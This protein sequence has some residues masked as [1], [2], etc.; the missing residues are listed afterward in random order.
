MKPPAFEYHA[1]GSIAETVELLD[2]LEDAKVLAGGQSL[3]PL[4]NFRLARPAHLV[5]VNGVGELDRVYRRD[6]G[7]A[8]GATVRQATAERH[9]LLGERCPLLPLAL[10]HVAHQVI[11]NRGTVCGSL[12][13]ADPA[14]ELCAVLLVLGGRV[15]ARSRRGER[16]IEA[17]ELFRGTFETSLEPDELIT[18]AWFPDHGPDVALVEE[19]RR[20]GDYAMAGVARAGERLALFG[21]AS[22]PVLADPAD[23]VRGLSP[24]AD[25]ES[26]AEF[27][28]HLVRVL[29]QRATTSGAA[30]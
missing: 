1:P 19:S 29:V 14:S 20:H 26:S 13:H 27:K 23:P 17:S 21:V 22:T 24:S 25:L 8:V 5:D 2:A 12:A 16:V 28:V 10:R 15:V 6:G 3:V 4:L 9:P 11:R 7:V 30:A 18:E